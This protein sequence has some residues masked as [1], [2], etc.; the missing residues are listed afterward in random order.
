M[1]SETAG[2]PS[3]HRPTHDLPGHIY[4]PFRRHDR[5]GT[6]GTKR[7]PWTEYVRLALLGITLVPLKGIFCFGGWIS[8]V[9]RCLPAHVTSVARS[10]C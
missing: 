6:M 2:K 7:Q 5:Y 8:H 3:N 10:V 9:Q 1:P 4:D